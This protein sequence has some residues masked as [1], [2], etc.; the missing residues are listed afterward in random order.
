MWEER[1]RTKKVFSI[2]MSELLPTGMIVCTFETE[3]VEAV[4]DDGQKREKGEW[5]RKRLGSLSTS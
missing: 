2:I 5:T 1:E 4:W 3:N